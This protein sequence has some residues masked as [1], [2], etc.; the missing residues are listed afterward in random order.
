M[1][2]QFVRHVESEKNSHPIFVSHLRIPVLLVNWIVVFAEQQPMP[3]ARAP[4]KMQILFSLRWRVHTMH[5]D[6]R[7]LRALVVRQSSLTV[8]INA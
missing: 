7:A 4:V 6:Q 5:M 3:C 2:G 8:G 1:S